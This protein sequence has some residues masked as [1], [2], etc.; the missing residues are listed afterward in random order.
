M[1]VLAHR[2]IWLQNQ[3]SL[4][5]MTDK[6]AIGNSNGGESYDAHCIWQNLSWCYP[7]TA[8]SFSTCPYLVL[9]NATPSLVPAI[10]FELENL[11]IA[12]QL[13][14]VGL[15][16]VFFLLLEP[17]LLIRFTECGCWNS[18]TG[19]M[20]AVADR[21]TAWCGRDRKGWRSS[22]RG[23]ECMAG[24]ESSR[25]ATN[26]LSISSFSAS[27]P[28]PPSTYLWRPLTSPS[29]LCCTSKH[30]SLTRLNGDWD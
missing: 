30:L 21:Q 14:W 10:Q 17:D 15:G 9:I 1:S 2:L 7:L 28:S 23:P 11:K 25:K 3:T 22:S 18:C 13:K 16:W 29:L 6:A 12:Q 26:S 20:E 24:E 27:A 5:E 19:A 8:S 4:K